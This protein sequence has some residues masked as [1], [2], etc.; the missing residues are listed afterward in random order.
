M[1]ELIFHV[2]KTKKKK[3]QKK[4]KRRIIFVSNKFIINTRSAEIFIVSAK[5]VGF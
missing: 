4:M 2:T 3:T 5:I 1:I